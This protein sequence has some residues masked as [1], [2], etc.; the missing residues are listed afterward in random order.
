MEAIRRPGV[1]DVYLQMMP[2]WGAEGSKIGATV[3]NEF[4]VT[5]GALIPSCDM[6]AV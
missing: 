4:L 1:V 3:I 6:N 2:L 5:K